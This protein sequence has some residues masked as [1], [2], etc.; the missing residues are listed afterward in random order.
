MYSTLE[1]IQASIT[2]DNLL[3]IAGKDQD[4]KR[5]IDT[6]IVNN[7]IEAA[8]GEIDGYLSEKY[9][10]P[11]STTDKIINNL[12]VQLAIGWLY[13]RTVSIPEEIDNSVKNARGILDKLSSGKLSL[14]SQKTSVSSVS[15]SQ[16]FDSL[17][18][19][20]VFS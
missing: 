18:F 11:L 16:T 4:G 7:A 6:E 15:I 19:K 20:D 1:D 3:M 13:S 5:V 2:E 9:S 8:D 10:V 12:S 17:Q 14:E